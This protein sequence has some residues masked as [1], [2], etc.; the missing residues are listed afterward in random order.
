M[1]E[2]RNSI[3]PGGNERVAVRRR[4]ALIL[5]AEDV[6][7]RSERD[8]RVPVVRLQRHRGEAEILV[9]IPDEQATPKNYD[10]PMAPGNHQR[11][12]RIF[13]TVRVGQIESVAHAPRDCIDGTPYHTAAATR[14]CRRDAPVGR[15]RLYPAA[16]RVERRRRH[17]CRAGL[18]AR[19]D[20]AEGVFIGFDDE[21]VVRAREASNGV[22][23]IAR[24][25]HEAIVE[26]ARH[27]T[28]I[29]TRGA[30]RDVDHTEIRSLAVGT[31]RDQRAPTIPAQVDDRSGQTREERCLDPP[32]GGAP[33]HEPVCA[34]ESH[35]RS[36]LV[37]ADSRAGALTITVERESR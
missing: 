15:D 6:P 34:R 20:D 35:R 22:D 16:P 30:G 26:G 24:A 3:A 4:E 13:R 19:I 32:T 18:R 33:R 11:L 9:E 10:E 12:G 21:L 36:R 5:Q 2:S 28:E 29:S 25:G 27:A 37:V 17:E 31:D 8:D 23:G 7:V 1:R 14:G